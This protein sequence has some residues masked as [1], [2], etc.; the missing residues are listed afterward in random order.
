MILIRQDSTPDGT[1]GTLI[2]ADWRSYRTIELPWL[3][4]M[5]RISSASMLE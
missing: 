1:P 2:L 3:S 5:T 4:N